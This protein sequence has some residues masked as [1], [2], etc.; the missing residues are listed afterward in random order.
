MFKLRF[1]WVMLQALFTRSGA[2]GEIRFI[3]W[4]WD[5]DIN[6]HLNNGNYLRFMDLGRWHWSLSSGTLVPMAR[7]GV[8]PMAVG[9]EIK[10][11]RALPPFARFR[12]V[13]SLDSAAGKTVRL[14]QR[15]YRGE[16][17]VAEAFVTA[18]FVKH[19]RAQ[20]LESV[21]PFMPHAWQERVKEVRKK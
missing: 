12:L 9:V 5:C 2:R 8:R 1:W 10:F 4:P 14:A 7:A 19:G 17:E 16:T 15:F 11:K 6:L 13:T 3:V 21:A 20:E 18:V